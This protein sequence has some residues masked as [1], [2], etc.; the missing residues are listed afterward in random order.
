MEVVQGCCVFF[1]CFVKCKYLDSFDKNWIKILELLLKMYSIY[2]IYLVKKLY[3]V[4]N[5]LY[6]SLK[7]MFRKGCFR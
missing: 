7:Y 1:Q 4:M 2:R 6:F 5:L 3:N